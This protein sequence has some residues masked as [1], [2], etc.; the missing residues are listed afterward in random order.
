MGGTVVMLQTR[1]W[2]VHGSNP[3]FHYILSI[4]GVSEIT[5]AF[6]QW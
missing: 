6:I 3:G 5:T 1:I 4:S 2:E